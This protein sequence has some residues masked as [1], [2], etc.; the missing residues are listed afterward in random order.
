MTKAFNYSR[1]WGKNV[2]V[3]WQSP[4]NYFCVPFFNSFNASIDTKTKQKT[5]RCFETPKQQ[6]HLE[7]PMILIKFIFSAQLVC[8]FN[9]FVITKAEDAAGE[10]N[11]F[12]PFMNNNLDLLSE[13]FFANLV[14]LRLLKTEP[15]R[16]KGWQLVLKI[17]FDKHF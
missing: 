16:L 1:F 17:S 12:F 13:T 10:K 14:H 5:R 2:S 6:N 4:E 11:N 9:H 3:Q 7:C 8:V 15:G